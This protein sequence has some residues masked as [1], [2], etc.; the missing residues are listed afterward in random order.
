MSTRH[1]LFG[2][3]DLAVLPS[4]DKAAYPNG[5][6]YHSAEKTVFCYSD[7]P[8][9]LDTT[10]NIV[11]SIE[12]STVYSCLYDD[13]T[14]IWGEAS[15]WAEAALTLDP[16]G[17]I[18]CNV[19]IL[20]DTGA[21]FFAASAPVLIET[22]PAPFSLKMF[23]A[24]LL[25]GFLEEQTPICDAK[26]ITGYSYNGV[27]LA[28]IP[29]AEL[30]GHKFAAIYGGAGGKY[31]LCLFSARPHVLTNADTG[32]DIGFSVSSWFLTYKI[33]ANYSTEEESVILAEWIPY[34]TETIAQTGTIDFEIFLED[35]FVTDGILWSSFDLY[36]GDEVL[37]KKASYIYPV[38][39]VIGNG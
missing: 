23:L 2:G 36:G 34:E 13:T 26:P 35:P 15:L 14:K 17:V 28:Q 9:H 27:P 5:L 16:V 8:F 7:Q 11:T 31:H 38:S 4:R 12:D 24:G 19:D 32:E 3:V 39:E 18:W 6:I 22:R 1:Y 10:Q 37:R 30:V 25:A 21:V 20:D 33:F 29:D